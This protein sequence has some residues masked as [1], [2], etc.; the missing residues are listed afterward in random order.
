[1]LARALEDAASD[2]AGDVRLDSLYGSALV[3]ERTCPIPLASLLGV[4]GIEPWPSRISAR[5]AALAFGSSSHQR[6]RTRHA[7]GPVI[8]SWRGRLSCD[9]L[10]C[11]RWRWR[12]HAAVPPCPAWTLLLD[13]V[14]AVRLLAGGNSICSH[15][16]NLR[17]TLLQLRAHLHAT[18]VLTTSRGRSPLRQAKPRVCLRH[19]FARGRYRIAYTTARCS[20]SMHRRRS[21]AGRG[22]GRVRL[23]SPCLWAQHLRPRAVAWCATGRPQRTSLGVV[24][25]GQAAVRCRWMSSRALA[26]RDGWSHGVWAAQTAW[27]CCCCG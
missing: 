15:L 14:L 25:G 24:Q 11:G 2:G 4:V 27:P 13:G 21:M 3:S 22:S 16:G 19:R 17:R 12:W 23:R 7:V 6:R 5:L 18:A 1:M 9:G 8:W 20:L 10:G 26:G